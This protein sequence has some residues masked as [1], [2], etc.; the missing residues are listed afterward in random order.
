MTVFKKKREGKAVVL[1]RKIGLK[2][3]LYEE[4]REGGI[5]WQGEREGGGGERL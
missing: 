3:H 4:E 2:R 5:D 1:E